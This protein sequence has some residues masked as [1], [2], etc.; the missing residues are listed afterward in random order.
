V[1]LRPAG[2]NLFSFSALVAA[3]P[4]AA[5]LELIKLGDGLRTHSREPKEDTVTARYAFEM[6]KM[7]KLL[8]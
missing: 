5:T 8:R 4:E 6:N 2:D 7:Y 1:T 3:T